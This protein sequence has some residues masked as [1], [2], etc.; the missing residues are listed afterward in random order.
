[1]SNVEV[2]VPY[3]FTPREYQKPFYNC[4]AD[5]YKRAWKT[6]DRRAGKD[7]TDF[8]LMIKETQKR[9]GGYYY[10]FPT[11]KRCKRDLWR[12][13]DKDGLK[14]LDHIPK[15]IMD[16]DPNET[17]MVI[18]FKNG[19]LIQLIGTD[20]FESIR[21]ANPIGCVYSE[22]ARQN[23]M[24]WE[25]VMPILE[26][27]DGWAIFNSTPNGKN[28]HYFMGERAKKH[29]NWF[30]SYL[31]AYDTKENAEETAQN[32][33]DDGMNEEMVQQECFCSFEP[34]S[35]VYTF[36]DFG[37]RG[38]DACSIWFSQFAPNQ[39]H[40]INFFSNS[41]QGL[42]YYVNVLQEWRQLKGV[43]W[44]K[45]VLPHDG[46]TMVPQTGKTN[47]QVLSEL[48][49]DCTVIPRPK[50]KGIAIEA[51]RQVL[52]KCLFHED[53]CAHGIEGMRQYRRERDDKNS[54]EGHPVY[55]KDAVHD[56]ASH[57]ADAFQTFAQWAQQNLHVTM[58]YILTR[59]PAD[60]G[61]G[62]YDR[63]GL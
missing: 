39:A 51:G 22:F 27:N 28:H 19:S 17:D 8:N 47:Y 12:Q 59:D 15:E 57:I 52:S 34:S 36:W 5:G 7:K 45:H 32:L 6:W 49:L 61:K 41:G 50:D 14:M 2:I 21:G 31:N 62:K 40:F 33:R 58:P 38:E 56:W 3:N 1:M 54:T 26:E 16:G 23:P 30:Y 29:P 20:D 42:E 13:I 35:P 60:T 48:G 4:I 9:V 55:Y 46:H 25:I 63:Y 18:K 10:F 43:V 44:G 53:N 37:T 11:Y 24:A